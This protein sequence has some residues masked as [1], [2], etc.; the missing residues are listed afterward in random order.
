MTSY[1]K[2]MKLLR[3]ERSRKR[4]LHLNTN[5]IKMIWL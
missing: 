4:W 2:L 3:I 5:G 1:S